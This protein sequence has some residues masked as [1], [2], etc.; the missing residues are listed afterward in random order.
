ML[1]IGSTKNIE[2]LEFVV[3]DLTTRRN[4]SS[5]KPV[6]SEAFTEGSTVTVGRPGRPAGSRGDKG[7]FFA[8]TLSYLRNEFVGVLVTIDPTAFQ[9]CRNYINSFNNKVAHSNDTDMVIHKQRNASVQEMSSE[10][11]TCEMKIETS[12]NSAAKSKARGKKKKSSPVIPAD[13][14]SQQIY[15]SE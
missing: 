6:H 9:K 5:P 2:T 7:K 4:T 15:V 3:E 14:I 10:T 13:T 12:V 1:M 8:S 11:K